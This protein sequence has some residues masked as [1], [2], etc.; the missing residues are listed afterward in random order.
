M[1]SLPND[2]DLSNFHRKLTVW[3]LVSVTFMLLMICAVLQ[4]NAICKW[5]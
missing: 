5:K 2:T 1:F 3:C 4:S